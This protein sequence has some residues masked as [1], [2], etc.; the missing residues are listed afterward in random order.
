MNYIVALGNPGP[1]YESTRH[2]VG[3]RALDYIISNF[4]LPPPTK[5]A[6]YAGRVSEGEIL[7]ESVLLLY[8]ETFMNH[9]GSAVKK[10]VPKAEISRLIVIYDDVALPLGEV[11]ISFGRG[12][13]G[14]NG[15]KSIIS[16]LG[17]KEFVR[18]RIGV[19]PTS[20]WTGKIKPLAGSDLSRF[21]LGKFTSREQA[22]LTEVFATVRAAVGVIVQ[23]GYVQAMNV[24]N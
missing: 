2:N 9:A 7:G 20:F 3:F 16:A 1:E 11:K 19:A 18:I 14:H 22:K 21:V 6:Q 4:N 17:S 13:G 12:D 10:M 15:I 24:Y 8:P 5:S 23:D